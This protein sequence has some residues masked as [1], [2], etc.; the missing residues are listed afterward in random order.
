MPKIKGCYSCDWGLSAHLI[1]G[2]TSVPGRLGQWQQL[3]INI[4]SKLAVWWP[5]FNI[6]WFFPNFSGL[7]EPLISYYDANDS[8][9]LHFWNYPCLKFGSNAHLMHIIKI[10]S[11]QFRS[12]M[13]I[14]QNGYK[15]IKQH[16]INALKI[17]FTFKV[18]P[19]WGALGI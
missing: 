2:L 10:T 15:H 5:K 13:Q 7:S 18:A 19:Q 3:K 9:D 16:K 6:N 12:Y 4:M 1:I 14:G 11:L 17:N 8:N